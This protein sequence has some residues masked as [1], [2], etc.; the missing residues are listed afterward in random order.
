MPISKPFRIITEGDTTDGR[1]V[2]RSWIE[3]MAAS[4]DRA[5]YGA[6][7]WLEHIRGILPDSPFKAYGD[8]VKLSTEEVEIDGKKLLALTGVV[9][10]T[11]ELVAM[12]KAR[13]K[14]YCSAEVDPNFAKSGKA[15]LAGLAVTDTPA[16]LGTEMMSFAAGLGEKNPLNPRKQSP[17]NLF[18]AAREISIEWEPEA[19]EQ[20]ESFGAALLGKVKSLLSGKTAADETNFSAVGQAV[21]AVAES[22][23]TLLDN[24]GTLQ[25]TITDM[26][27]ALKAQT[28]AAAADRQAF[29]DL[30][31][32]LD[33][34]D[35]NPGRPP[36][37]GGNGDQVTDC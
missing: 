30:K 4:Y 35:P 6:R 16:S 3:Q 22:Q 31:K 9:D 17:L 11:P 2:D 32:S 28:D 10:G 5:K 25:K 7:V 19:G 21:T 23:K 18:S 1:V 36:A 15:Y 34:N 26:A 24:F 8:V 27:A 37:S 29:A 12:H 13:Q 14:I 33:E 20:N